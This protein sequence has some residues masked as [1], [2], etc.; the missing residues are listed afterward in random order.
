[1]QKSGRQRVKRTV[2]RESA[3]RFVEVVGGMV[4]IVFYAFL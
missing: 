4:K 1:M 3:S 2:G